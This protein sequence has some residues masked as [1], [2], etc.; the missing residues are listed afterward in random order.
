MFHNIRWTSQKIANYLELIHP[1]VYRSRIQLPPFRYHE[2]DDPVEEPLV[3]LE[4]DDSNWKR[5]SVNSNWGGAN[6][7]FLLRTDFQVPLDWRQDAILVLHLPIG[8]E[9]DFSHPEALA[10]ID[11]TPYAG[12]DRH[13]QEILLPKEILPGE[14][15]KLALHGWTGS[16]FHGKR[17]SLVMGDC[18]L[19][20]IDQPTRDFIALA[21]VALGVADHLDENNPV[22]TH[23]FNSLNQAFT[24]LELREPYDEKLYESIQHAYHSLVDGIKLSGSSIEVEI[25]AIGHAHLDLGWLWTLAQTRRKAGRTF[26]SII[27]LMEQYPDF[28]FVQSQPQLYE[29]IQQ[30]YPDLFDTVQQRVK[31]GAWEVIGGM[32]VEADCNISGGE[33]LA[34]Q[35]LLGRSYF[36][37]Y[38]GKEAESPVLWL[39][40]V[41]GFSWNLPQLIKEAGLDYFFTIKIG[42]SQYNR[43]PYDSFWWQGLDGTR[44]LTHFSTT[45][46]SED[47]FVST[48]N[49]TASPDAVLATWQNFQ[50]KDWGKAGSIP[51]LLMVYGY[52]DGGG[53]PTQE[54]IENINLLESFPGTPRVKMSKVKDFFI[55]L[56][57]TSGDHLPIWNDEL[58]LE[59]HRGTYTSQAH[60]KRANRKSEFLLHDVEFLAAMA[61]VLDEDFVYPKDELGRAWQLVCLNQFHDILAGTSIREVHEEALDQYT[62]VSELSQKVKNSALKVFAE[63]IGGDL[64]I[65]NPTSFNRIDFAFLEGEFSPNLSISRPDGTKARVQKV[66]GGYLLDI[67]DIAPFSVVPLLINDSVNPDLRHNNE[68]TKLIASKRSLENKFLRI[69]INDEGDISSVYNKILGQEMV[70]PGSVANQFQAFQDRPKTPDAWEIDIFYDDKMWFARPATSITLVE[71]GKLR[72]TIEVRREVLNSIIVQQISIAY[73]SCRIDFQTRLDWHDKNTLL[74]AAFPVEVLSPNATYEIPWGDIQRPTHR[75]NSWDW[76]K[77]EVPAQK[78]VDLS[79]G[80]HGVSLLN[81]SMYGHDIHDNVIRI[82]L[83][84]SPSYPDPSADLGEHE[85]VYSLLPHGSEWKLNTI[86]EAYTLNDPLITYVH[87]RSSC[88]KKDM[89]VPFVQVDQQNVIIETIKAA[90]DGQGL[91]LRMYECQRK[92]CKCVLTA[93][94]DISEGFRT[95]LIEDNLHT[96]EIDGNR[97]ML[98]I[99]PYQIITIRL[100]PAA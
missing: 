63:N 59:Y 43:L 97:V 21:R 49:A 87:P 25:T 41:F 34:R 12:I 28:V 3:D 32:W 38:F 96:L 100:I 50:Q 33:A 40:D 95:N 13:H 79:E 61:S 35:F 73:N 53:G 94:F 67:G 19:V 86:A 76:A 55:K 88:I 54:M 65:I 99:K 4:I 60:N 1:H 39:P 44:V 42:W 37:R 92:R 68:N 6:V 84:R 90:E 57:S 11:G 69:T 8:E 45:K 10:S 56:E 30:D 83:L 2:L 51:P 66:E 70:S 80:G 16:L 9:G 75:N 5:I 14:S 27:R 58:Y 22:R 17:V 52:G 64:L 20:V 46:E 91:I 15:H 48:Y 74:K 62:E 82:T 26:H 23:L 98:E 77:F 24:L 93:G 71:E 85:F 89:Q 78:W 36:R 31:E 18:A 7:N 29:Y 72:A 81:D 47:T